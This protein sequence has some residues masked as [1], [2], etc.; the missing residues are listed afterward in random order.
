MSE[1]DIFAVII[2]GENMKK[3]ILFISSLI[4]VIFI[5]FIFTNYKTYLGKRPCDQ[6]GTVWKSDDGAITFS[7]DESGVG[8]GWIDIHGESVPIVVLIGP[9]T[10]VDIYPLS[11]IVQNNETME[12][13][14]N[15]CLEH[16]LGTFKKDSEFIAVVEDS[17]YYSIGDRI[18]F[19][20]E[21]ENQGENQGTVLCEK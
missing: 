18:Y 20:R 4:L 1:I 16:W 17:T 19:Y 12:V 7:I 6:P 15:T 13:F 9:A 21:K 3:K 5:S 2:W 14:G 10:G 11:S 8:K